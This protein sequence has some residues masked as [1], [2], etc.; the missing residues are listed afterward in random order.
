M[1]LE[2]TAVP[3]APERR[4]R[5]GIVGRTQ[6]RCL[7]TAERVTVDGPDVGIELHVPR[8][9]CAA[10]TVGYTLHVDPGLSAAPLA[11]GR[12]YRVSV[13]SDAG[14]APGLVA[15]RVLDT[16]ISGAGAPQPENG[17]WWSESSIE[18]GP[19]SRSTGVSLE[20]QG[21]QL[22]VSLFG[23]GDEGS[24]IWYFGSARQKGRTAVVPLLGLRNGDP[25][26]SPTGS[27]PDATEGLR[28]EFEFLSPSRARAWLVR[29]DDR[30]DVAVRAFT[31]SRS[32]FA[33]ADAGADWSGRWVLVGDDGVTLQEF[34][35][36]TPTRQDADTSRFVGA[37]GASLDCRRNGSSSI[38]DLCTLSTGAATLADFDQIGLDRLDGRD[39]RGARV[40]LLRVSRP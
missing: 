40:R 21:G 31:L 9:G 33:T 24:P 8:T 34:E 4:L 20:A 27:R 10:G 32:N 11:P 37:D 6:A 7:P 13:F 22:A 23:F 28:L 30:R 35:F 25:L 5:I 19:A 1:R 38:P 18:T 15:F 12:I 14:D 39:S 36:E 17:F 3:T 2:S 16:N 29:S 26:F